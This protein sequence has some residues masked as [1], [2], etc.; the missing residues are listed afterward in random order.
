MNGNEWCDQCDTDRSFT[1]TNTNLCNIHDHFRWYSVFP[2]CL[3]MCIYPFCS[4][5]FILYTNKVLFSCT[6]RLFCTLNQLHVCELWPI[7][8][9]PLDLAISATYLENCGATWPVAER[10]TCIT[11]TLRTIT[12]WQESKWM[13]KLKYHF[14]RIVKLYPF[15]FLK[16]TEFK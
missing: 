1:C 5:I 15:F 11:F 13:P 7:S 9:S 3:A 4:K 10:Y 16:K 14:Y 8:V 6:M 12:T 2:C